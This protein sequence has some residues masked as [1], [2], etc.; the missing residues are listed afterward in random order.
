[1][2]IKSRHASNY[3][4]IPNDIFK[5]KLSFEAIGLLTYF[6]SLPND[7]AIKKTSLHIQLNI[8]RDKIDRMFKELQD[9]G[10]INSVKRINNNG[11]YTHDHIVYDKPYN[12][13]PYAEEPLTDK[14]YTEKPL[15]VNGGALL[16]KDIQSTNILNTNKLNK[17]GDLDLF[18]KDEFSNC[19][20][21]FIDYRKKIKK[22]IKFVSLNKCYNN[23][24]ELSKNDP[25]IAQKIIDQS[26]AN[27]WTGLFELKENK[28]KEKS[29]VKKEKEFNDFWGDNK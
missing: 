19:F 17:E 16:S 12:G 1:M 5:S 8:G 7:W 21:E 10:Y 14:P 22:P 4:V 6:L 18:I 9:V 23:L 11:T 20:Y 13:E 25:I 15:T 29:S 27:S 2:I 28:E 26:I 3:T 24:I